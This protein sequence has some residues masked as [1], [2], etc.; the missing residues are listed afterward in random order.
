MDGKVKVIVFAHSP[1]DSSRLT[2]RQVWDSRNYASPVR[3][4]SPRSGN[5]SALEWSQRGVLAVASGAT[6]NVRLSTQGHLFTRLI[7]IFGYRRIPP[8][9]FKHVIPSQLSPLCISPI[10]FHLVQ[11]LHHR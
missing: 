10:L 1:V 9:R 8:Q 11:N 2:V 6:V 5:A 4:W 3:E 7:I